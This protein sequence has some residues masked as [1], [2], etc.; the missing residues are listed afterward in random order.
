M[1]PVA[2]MTAGTLR[3]GGDSVSHSV[4]AR[5]SSGAEPATD[6]GTRAER[7]ERPPRVGGGT[8]ER[9]GDERQAGTARR[10]NAGAEASLL[11]E[12]V[13][14]RNLTAVRPAEVQAILRDLGATRIHTSKKS[15]VE[16]HR[17]RRARPL[18]LSRCAG[19]H[20]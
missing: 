20:L 2:S 4:Q 7:P 17:T 5:G 15:H 11:M 8:A 19:L 13:L 6:A 16:R 14:R 10:G 9:T 3:G 12:E 18:W 1:N